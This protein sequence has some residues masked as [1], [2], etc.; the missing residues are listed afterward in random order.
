MLE[1][2]QIENM[3]CLLAS[4]DRHRLVQQLHTYPADFPIDFTD[5]YL[6]TLST[7]RL[8]HLFMAIC[9]QSQ[10]MPELTSPQTA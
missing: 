6:A 7:D 10:R 3:M 1:A 9:I 2:D 8:R 5:E 4:L